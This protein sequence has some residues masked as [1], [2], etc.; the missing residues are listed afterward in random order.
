MS[1]VAWVALLALSVSVSRHQIHPA[2]SPAEAQ[3]KAVWERGF[4][5]G[6]ERR[7]YGK[8]TK[9]AVKPLGH[10]S[11]LV[12][13]HPRLQAYESGYRFGRK[14]IPSANADISRYAAVGA[15][16][17]RSGRLRFKGQIYIMRPTRRGDQIKD[18]ENFRI[19][20]ISAGE[21]RQP[22]QQP[23]TLHGTKLEDWGSGTDFM[24]IDDKG[25][26][27]PVPYT[28]SYSYYYAEFIAEFEM[29][30]VNQKPIFA[31]GEEQITVVVSG[32]F[33]RYT[34]KFPL[35]PWKT[36]FESGK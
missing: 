11:E 26:T 14:W 21:T 16:L 36:A 33:G 1:P 13:E 27:I 35:V 18:L 2:L 9:F 24:T 34:A 10:A 17:A 28:Y 6:Q 30:D 20:L 22:V 15:I 19:E 29:L 8:A 7:D 32:G 25:T 3:L 5:D 31:A 12:L 23:G 4:R